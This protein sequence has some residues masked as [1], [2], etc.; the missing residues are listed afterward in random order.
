MC[1]QTPALAPGVS[2]LRTLNAGVNLK[3]RADIP[4]GTATAHACTVMPE[5]Q[6]TL[7]QSSEGK[8]SPAASGYMS[9]EL[10]RMELGT[11]E[12]L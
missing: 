6:V 7:A 4:A 11:E 5:Q 9:S 10:Y 2:P 1:S 12:Q 8:S 3:H